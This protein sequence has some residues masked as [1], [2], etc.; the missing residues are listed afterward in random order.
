[1]TNQG[2]HIEDNGL[3]KDQKA[4]KSWEGQSYYWMP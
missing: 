1:M 3:V 4:K 2:F